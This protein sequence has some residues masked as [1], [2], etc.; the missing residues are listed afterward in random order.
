MCTCE[1]GVSV[2]E[3]PGP[4]QGIVMPYQFIAEGVRIVTQGLFRIGIYRT[5]SPY[6]AEQ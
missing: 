2:I 1:N 3:G 4:R 6:G 5:V